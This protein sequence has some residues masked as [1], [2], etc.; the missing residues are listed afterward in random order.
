MKE[1]LKGCVSAY[2]MQMV[3]GSAV[4]SSKRLKPLIILDVANYVVDLNATDAM[5]ETAAKSLM[6]NFLQMGTKIGG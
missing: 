5:A 6:D 1:E 4:G 2:G 3:P